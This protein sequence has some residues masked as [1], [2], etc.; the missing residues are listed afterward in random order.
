MSVYFSSQPGPNSA[1]LVNRDSTTSPK[2]SL[3]VVRE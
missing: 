1:T 2:Q 3:G